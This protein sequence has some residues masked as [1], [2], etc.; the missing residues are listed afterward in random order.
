MHRVTLGLLCYL[1]VADLRPGTTPQHMPR[2]HNVQIDFWAPLVDAPQS[3]LDVELRRAVWHT[4]LAKRRQPWAILSTGTLPST[5]NIVI[6][7]EWAVLEGIPGAYLS[8][9]VVPIPA[10]LLLA[11]RRAFRMCV[12]ANM[13][14]RDPELLADH[15]EFE[16]RSRTV[17]VA[18]ESLRKENHMDGKPLLHRTN[19]PPGK[20]Q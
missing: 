3:A 13:R 12:R 20:W 4:T 11:E 10:R 7:R 14:E 8:A 18:I 2:L 5:Q 19:V 6:S 16:V 1:A 15:P 9:F 17:E